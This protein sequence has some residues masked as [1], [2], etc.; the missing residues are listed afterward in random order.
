MLGA[1]GTDPAVTFYGRLLQGRYLIPIVPLAVA[2]VLAGL[3]AWSRRVALAGA[4]LLLAS[5]FV[6]SIAGLNT[7]LRFYAT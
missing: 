7:V 3:H 1:R 6:I 5:W 4:A 2:A